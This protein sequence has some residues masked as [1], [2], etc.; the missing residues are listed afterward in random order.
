MGLGEVE[1]SSTAFG[2][3]RKTRRR[4]ESC[5]ERKARFRYHGVVKADR[6][7]TL[8]FECYRAERERRR[9]QLLAADPEGQPSTL[10]AFVPRTLSARASAHRR[11]MLEHLQAAARSTLSRPAAGTS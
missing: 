9:A 6:D 4:C 11:R 2:Q 8:C 1:M 7:H 3:S 5:Q 10:S